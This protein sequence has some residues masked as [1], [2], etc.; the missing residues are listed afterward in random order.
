MSTGMSGQRSPASLRIMSTSRVWDRT[1][2]A[3]WEVRLAIPTSRGAS[4]CIRPPAERSTWGRSI[5]IWTLGMSMVRATVPEP[6]G[7]SGDSSRTH[8]SLRLKVLDLSSQESSPTTTGI[9]WMPPL[10]AWALSP[11][12]DA[13]AS[14]QYSGGGNAPRRLV[15]ESIDSAAIESSVLLPDC[16]HDGPLLFLSRTQ[17]LAACGDLHSGEDPDRSHGRFTLTC[18]PRSCVPTSRSSLRSRP[19]S[20]ASTTG[21]LDLGMLRSTTAPS[22]VRQLSTACP[23]TATDAGSGSIPR[24]R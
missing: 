19:G 15:V 4:C 22:K 23:R 18:P 14:L 13:V 1:G 11:R 8:P 3:S 16:K 9:T 12:G 21:N 20:G 24:R 5:R 2:S 10:R 6:P 7:S 17:L